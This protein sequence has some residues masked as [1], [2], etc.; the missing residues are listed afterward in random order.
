MSSE[1][2]VALITGICAVIGQYL[3]SRQQSQ[4]R[5][6]EEAARDARLEE[7]LKSVEHKLDIHNGYAEKFA[8]LGA[9]IAELKADV[10]NL[11]RH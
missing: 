1:I 4:N 2:V 11:Y 7:R 8:S 6:K 10:K 9:D 3:I 5:E